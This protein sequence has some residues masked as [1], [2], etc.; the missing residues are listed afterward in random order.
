MEM[1]R[2]DNS[3]YDYSV[4]RLMIDVNAA[5]DGAFAGGATRV[6]VLDSHGGG[7]NFDISLL[8]K[9]A[10]LDCKE[11]KKWWGKLDSSYDGTF[12]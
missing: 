5:I 2:R 7:G 10:D 4:K 11:N 9:R 1:I 8:D 3:G 12:L 6:T